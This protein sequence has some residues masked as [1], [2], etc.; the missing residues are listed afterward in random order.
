MV[1]G[2]LAMSSSAASASTAGFGPLT[3]PGGVFN[4]LTSPTAVAVSP[5]GLNVYVAYGSVGTTVASSF[6]ALAI[7]K[8]EPATGAISEVGCLSSDGTDGVD[9]AS[10]VCT[11]MPSLLGA[12]GVAVSPN[13]LSVFVTSS[14][15]GAV[16]AFARE[17]SDGALTRLGCFQSRPV[18]GAP[19]KYGN[20]FT[21]SGALAVG[22]DN[23]SLYI[24]APTV[25]SIS[26][27]TAGLIEPPPAATSSVSAQEWTVAS[28]FGAPT[29]QGLANP[30]IAVNGFDGDCSVGIATQGL[31]SVA[32]SPE[33]NQVYAAAPGSDAVD[34]FTPNAA[35]VLSESSCIKVN[36]PPG[37]CSSAKLMTSP[38]RLVVSPDGR[39]VYA[40][41]AGEDG[42]KV[43]VFSRNPTTGTLTESS[44]VDFLPPEEHAENS[45]EE[46][47]EE[48][49]SEEESHE[50]APPP[51]SCTK[52][53]GLERVE[54][55][56][57]SGDG[58]QVYAFG[59]DSFV[60]FSRD[61]STG[62]LTEVSCASK[63]DSRCAS[64]PSLD[65]VN[66]AAISS[67]G[68][69][70]Y[71]TTT[72]G[73]VRVFALG[74]AV[75]SERVSATSAGLARIA[76]ACPR[77]LKRPCLGRVMLV[78]SLT[79]HI[80]M[81]PRKRTHRRERDR[82]RRVGAG[83]SA[84]FTIR[85]GTHETISVRL[86]NAALRLLY[87]HRRLRLMAVVLA[88]PHTGGSGYGRPVLFDLSRPR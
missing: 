3:G 10:G 48:G 34:V 8:R 2:L 43:D 50:P 68:R 63:E 12:D 11:A 79:E 5:D 73:D 88:Q 17:P 16:V 67:D 65:G 62:G 51:D 71:V 60:V 69:E 6:G 28:I 78:R 85:P 64:V 76:V 9:G 86:S 37:L 56:A 83:Q 66:S 25:G 77:G 42:G 18:G 41:D 70:V 14:F 31:D 44:C 55:L 75:T 4:G 49:N 30:C 15:S 87:S 1:A 32:L 36:A 58:S 47:H 52:V 54:A 29:T 53:P 57:V 59:S 35:G 20:V 40:A 7:L 21:S 19:C 84:N 33:G 72:S 39:N 27:L 80:H 22:A 46:S 38:T 74:A 45:E 23:R 13:G 61:P 82:V 81:K 24:A 26:T